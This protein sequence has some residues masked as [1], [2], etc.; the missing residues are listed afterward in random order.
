MSDAK[1]DINLSRRRLFTNMVDRFT[2]K[3][4]KDKALAQRASNSEFVQKANEFF[5]V[6]DYT[7]AIPL[8]RKVLQSETDNAE[9]HFQ[10][11]KSLYLQ[12]KFSQARIEFNILHKK[13]TKNNPVLLYLGLSHCCLG[14]MDKAIETWKKFF[15][16]SLVELQRELNLQIACYEDGDNTDIA[17]LVAQIEELAEQALEE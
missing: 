1:N 12:K 8:Y 13:N 16:P 17:A 14:D 9:V 15:A 2:K 3:D 11:S 6:A 7:Q 10:L 5:A 4:E